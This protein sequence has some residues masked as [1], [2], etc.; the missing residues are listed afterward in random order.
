MQQED[1]QANEKHEPAVSLLCDNLQNPKKQIQA[2]KY[3][4]VEDQLQK[5]S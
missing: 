5:T 3:A 4:T 2:I 1:Q